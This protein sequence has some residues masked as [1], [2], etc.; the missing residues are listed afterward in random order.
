M[1][2]QVLAESFPDWE[3]AVQ[4][5][6]TDDDEPVDSKLVAKQ[7][8][9]L[10]EPLYS[11]WQPEPFEE[12]PNVIRKF[13]ADS[14]VGIFTSPYHPAIVPDMFLS[15]DVETKGNLEE[16]ENRSYCIWVH[17]KPPEAVLEIISDK[18]GGEFD[19]KMR[20]YGRMGVR[21]YVTF[22]PFQIYDAPYLRVYERAIS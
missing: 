2:P 9:L 8:R 7:E 3:T 13:Y 12:E 15:L 10:V 4:N 17:E 19:E 6:V 20:R 16:K 18:R 5:M 11:S 1:M 21:Y 14:N 22:D